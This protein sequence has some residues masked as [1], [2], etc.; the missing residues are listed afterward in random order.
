MRFLI[1]FG[2]IRIRSRIT[3]VNFRVDVGEVNW[4]SEREG[5]RGWSGGRIARPGIE[6]RSGR[7]VAGVDGVSKYLR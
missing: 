3:T 6:A 4:L 5:G 1:T 7:M 2:S